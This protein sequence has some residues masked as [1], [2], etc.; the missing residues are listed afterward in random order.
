MPKSFHKKG[1]KKELKNLA[2]PG[3]QE[4]SRASGELIILA[5]G[6]A[7]REVERVQFIEPGQDFPGDMPAWVRN[8]P[9]EISDILSVVEIWETAIPEESGGEDQ[10]VDAD[11]KGKGKKR[12]TGGN[13]EPYPEGQLEKSKE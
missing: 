9:W 11:P 12:K 5:M 8:S 1:A 4:Y 2:Q 10:Q 13:E 3:K 6:L 7:L